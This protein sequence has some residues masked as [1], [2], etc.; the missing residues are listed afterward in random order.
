MKKI[1]TEQSEE[2][3]A[4]KPVPHKS[5]ESLVF[6]KLCRDRDEAACPIL[7]EPC[8]DLK[9][10]STAN[11]ATCPATSLWHILLW[12]CSLQQRQELGSLRSVCCII[13]WGRDPIHY[14]YYWSQLKRQFCLS[15]VN[16]FSDVTWLWPCKNQ[17]IKASLAFSLQTDCT[18]VIL[19]L[20][21]SSR[22]KVY[23]E[24]KK[25][26]PPSFGIISSLLL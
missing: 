13:S 21:I 19:C 9:F 14:Y 7:P 3:L 24:E 2:N 11:K 18:F 8:P 17:Y 12:E 22:R 25:S 5:F 6:K 15:T 1:D 20:K 4:T 16:Y 10:L 26:S 23:I